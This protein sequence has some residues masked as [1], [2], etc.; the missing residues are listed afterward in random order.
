[1]FAGPVLVCA[2]LARDVPV[3]GRVLAAAVVPLLVWQ[4]YGPIRETAKGLVDPSSRA[5]FYEPVIA[6]IEGRA[7]AATR[8]EIPF[9]RMHW[10][11]VHVA[12]RL[13]LARGWETQLDVKYNPL[14]RQGRRLTAE[15]YHHW[16]QANGVRYVALPDVPLDPA[17]RQE[18]VLIRR[19]LPFLREVWADRR[20]RLFEVVDA[21]SLGGRDARV[22]AIGPTSFTLDARRRGR[23]V[24]R[25]RWTPYWR[26]A[27]GVACVRRGP[28]GWTVI[29]AARPGVVR[30]AAHFDPARIV[31]R[32]PRCDRA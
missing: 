2:L 7:D 32:G 20:W 26:V 5:A 23:H 16:L 22:R 8:V 18:A 12:R 28:D 13:P 11:S 19:G 21:S 29:E 9:T 25:V 27:R 10:E 17:A 14:F 3:R 31:R 24:V 4:W 30:V 1:M 6:Q 15:R